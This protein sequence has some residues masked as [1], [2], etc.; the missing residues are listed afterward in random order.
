M[1]QSLEIKSLGETSRLGVILG[2]I[3]E[4]GDIIC[5]EGDLGAGKTTLTQSIAKGL[6]ISKEYYVTSP[7]F[8]ILHEYEGRIP[9]FHMDFYRLG[10][11]DEVID[12]GFEDYFYGVGLTV[13]EWPSR[14]Y[15]VIPEG[16][17]TVTIKMEN[18]S[19]SLTLSSPANSSWE[20]K[21][22]TVIERFNCE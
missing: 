17:L 16:F 18:N 1:K 22:N 4:P 3:A 5:L 20:R 21:M 6:D 15:G 13:I 11:E 14:A 19:R 7:S 10:G 12:L 2:E 8:A 9:L